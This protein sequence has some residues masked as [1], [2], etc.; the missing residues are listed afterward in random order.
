M[1]RALILL[2]VGTILSGAAA[3]ATT[4]R[5]AVSHTK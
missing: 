5:T 3:Y 4:S 2:L 1:K